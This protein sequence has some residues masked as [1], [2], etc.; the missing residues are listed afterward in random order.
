MGLGLP[1]AKRLV[2]RMGGRIWLESAPWEGSVFHFTV[3]LNK[4]EGG[5]K[6]GRASR[7]E[8]SKVVASGNRLRALVADDDTTNLILLTHFLQKTGYQ[9]LAVENGYQVLKAMEQQNFDVILMDVRMPGLNGLEA[10]RAIRESGRDIPIIAVTACAM[11]EDRDICLAAGMDGYLSKPVKFE[12]L[13]STI[14]K[15]TGKP[16]STQ[17]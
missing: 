16:L 15:A 3:R 7:T 1:I 12:E 9:T 11:P 17:K 4:D 13:L 2:E 8:N 6:T 5:A 14:E 10:T